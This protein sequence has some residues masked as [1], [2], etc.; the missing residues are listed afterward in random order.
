MLNRSLLTL[1]S[2]SESF[3]LNNALARVPHFTGTYPPLRDFIADIR[4]AITYVPADLRASFTLGVIA[5]LQGKARDS[6]CGKTI[7]TPDELIRHLKQ[8]FAPGKDYS[9]YC[10]RLNNLRMKQGCSVGDFYD[11]ITI[12]LSG[13][14]AAL[15]DTQEEAD[16]E[17]RQ[18]NEDNL[19]QMCK[20]MNLAAIDI[21]IRG[22]EPHMA[23][24]VDAIKPET[25]EEAYEAARRYESRVEASILPGSRTRRFEEDEIRETRNVLLQQPPREI[26]R[27]NWA[28]HDIPKTRGGH[29]EWVPDVPRYGGYNRKAPNY[30]FP[31]NN[32]PRNAQFNQLGRNQ[33]NS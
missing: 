5:K 4:N 2:L 15:K 9:Y 19:E 12:L 10:N 1:A 13:V 17:G 22:L 26:L 31:L 25:L 24:A 29:Y 28:E 32:P 27:R 3:S 6:V 33:E 14:R 7:A 18:A 8:R 30:Q 21:F 23:R 11:E 20:P 16:D